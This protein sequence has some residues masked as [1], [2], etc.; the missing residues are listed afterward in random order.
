MSHNRGPA[1]IRSR[2]RQTSSWKASKTE[3]ERSILGPFASAALSLAS[4]PDR[5]HGAMPRSPRV[6]TR[7][8]PAGHRR[9]R[10]VTIPPRKHC[11]EFT[12]RPPA[13]SGRCRAR[14]A[15]K[16][17]DQPIEIPR[18]RVWKTGDNRKDRADRQL[19]PTSA[20]SGDERGQ[21]VG[22]PY[23]PFK[24]VP[25]RERSQSGCSR[26]RTTVLC[27]RV[28][29]PEPGKPRKV[30]IRCANRSAMFERDR[31][32]DG[33]RQPTPSSSPAKCR[34]PLFPTARAGNRW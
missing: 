4:T 7:G 27:E 9:R 30:A 3:A 17:Q 19:F 24:G 21:H 13:E 11:A 5:H 25:N 16:D 34:G 22:S 28:R 10:P 18:F 1:R 14:D 23:V 6:Q 29:P 20:G 15:T 32:E 2:P 31:G 33:V 8:E 12:L 26:V